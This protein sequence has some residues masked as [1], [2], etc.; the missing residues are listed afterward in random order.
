[1][2][3]PE[4]PKLQDLLPE[5]FG[6][7]EKGFKPGGMCT[8]GSGCDPAPRSASTDLLKMLNGSIPSPPAPKE[9]AGGSTQPTHE[10]DSAETDDPEAV[11]R[12]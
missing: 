5:L 10:T 11:P 9:A 4:T 7:P 6:E 1:M 8:P 3:D 12:K 2:K